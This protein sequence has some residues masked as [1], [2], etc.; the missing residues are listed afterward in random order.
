MNG[1]PGA[2]VV[3][4]RLIG[5]LRLAGIT[6]DDRLLFELTDI[7]RQGCESSQR[8]LFDWSLAQLNGRLVDT[9]PPV[10]APM[11]P[12]QRASIGYDT[13][14]HDISQRRDSAATTQR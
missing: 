9:T 3:L 6:I 10:A 12:L 14:R 8:A 1:R 2:D 4:I 5:Y 7:V 11:P 13:P